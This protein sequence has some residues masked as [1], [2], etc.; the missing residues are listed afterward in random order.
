MIKFVIWEDYFDLSEEKNVG[1]WKYGVW[2][3]VFLR[4]SRKSF[5][6]K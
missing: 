6:V 4:E 1:W 2:L 3:G 5:E